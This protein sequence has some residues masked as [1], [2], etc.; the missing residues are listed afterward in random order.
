VASIKSIEDFE[1]KFVKKGSEAFQQQWKTTKKNI[2]GKMDM[3]ESH[4]HADLKLLKQKWDSF[5]HQH[6]RHLAHRIHFPTLKCGGCGKQY[7][8]PEFLGLVESRGYMIKEEDWWTDQELE[9][10]YEGWG[11]WANRSAVHCEACEA[12]AWRNVEFVS[13]AE[14]KKLEKERIKNQHNDN[15]PRD[16]L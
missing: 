2:M 5:F 15:V 1:S 9:E 13:E 6:E 3:L 7:T 8:L 4:I 10:F 16:E 12:V 14:E 11:E